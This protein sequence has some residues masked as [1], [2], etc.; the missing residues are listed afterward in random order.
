MQAR[1]LVAVALL[2]L[3]A[4]SRANAGC[5]DVVNASSEPVSAVR[6]CEMSAPGGCEVVLFEG[7]LA[8]GEAVNVCSETGWIIYDQPDDSPDG[9]GEP[10]GA[11]C[12]GTEVQL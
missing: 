2:T 1:L 6:I 9:Y 11:E 7:P 3:L 12:D 8:P 5:C 4:A 10:T